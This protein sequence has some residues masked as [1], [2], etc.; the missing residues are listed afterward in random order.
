MT[1]RSRRP[2]PPP[3]PGHSARVSRP[4]RARHL[5][6]GR[7][8]Q[9]RRNPNRDRRHGRTSSI[10]AKSRIG[11]SYGTSDWSVPWF[12]LL[13]DH[14]RRLPGQRAPARLVVDAHDRQVAWVR[15]SRRPSAPPHSAAEQATLV[16]QATPLIVT[17]VVIWRRGQ[18]GRGIGNRCRRRRVSRRGAATEV[19]ASVAPWAA[20]TV[21]I[22][23]WLMA[24]PNLRGRPIRIA[25][26]TGATIANSMAETPRTSRDYP[27]K[28]ALRR[29]RTPSRV[30]T[31]AE[32]HRRPSMTATR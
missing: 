15:H 28:S 13:L 25:R 27:H 2:S 29:V 21:S 30:R 18:R 20:A 23:E 22:R 11:R 31:A 19:T 26:E 14:L 12:I 24:T 1:A 3:G 32:R 7:R 16:L 17:V 5:S 4:S 8:R 10:T 9:Q 6:P